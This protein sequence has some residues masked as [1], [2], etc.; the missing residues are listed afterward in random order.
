M[1]TLAELTTRRDELQAKLDS[2]VLNLREGEK[3]VGYRPATEMR[4]ALDDLNRQINVLSG[5]AA[6]P[7][8]IRTFGAK[9]V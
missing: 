5:V 1:A 6:K 3:Q 4:N 7:R 2:G 9:G 8:Q